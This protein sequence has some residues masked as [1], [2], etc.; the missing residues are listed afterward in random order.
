MYILFKPGNKP[1]LLLANLLETRES[2]RDLTVKRKELSM[3]DRR[4]LDNAQTAAIEA[5]RL[6]KASRS[7]NKPVT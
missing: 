3:S 2:K 7:I 5:Y 1:G 6:L 4:H